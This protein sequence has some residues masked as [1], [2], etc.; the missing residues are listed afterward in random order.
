MAFFS[1][2]VTKP[3]LHSPVYQ[4][5]VRWEESVS[6]VQAVLPART[7]ANVTQIYQALF[8]VTG[9]TIG[10]RRFE[11]SL[12][13]VTS[14]VAVGVRICHPGVGWF[15]PV[16]VKVAPSVPEVAVLAQVEVTVGTAVDDVLRG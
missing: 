13:A 1:T 16:V 4:S 15:Q 7:E 5:H 12:A 3:K 2:I 6:R 9:P 8:A 14:P 10:F 11:D